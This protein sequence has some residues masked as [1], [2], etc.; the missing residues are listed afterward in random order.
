MVPPPA[1]AYTTTPTTS[2]SCQLN[3][4]VG[5][6]SGAGGG[7]AGFKLSELFCV[8]VQDGAKNRQN[9]VLLRK[10]QDEDIEVIMSSS[11]DVLTEHT[12]LQE[13][14][15]IRSA[16]IT[17]IVQRE[18]GKHIKSQAAS[19]RKHVNTMTMQ[20]PCLASS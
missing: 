1:L 6:S 17:E 14:A 15:A 12:I 2:S 13:G 9:G 7:E 4:D 3:L 11:C 18:L 10:E 8:H 19:L 5:P 16:Q 20:D